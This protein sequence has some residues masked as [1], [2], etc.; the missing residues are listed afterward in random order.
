MVADLAK[1]RAELETRLRAVEAE[2]QPA[3]ALAPAQTA[4][5]VSL[6]RSRPVGSGGARRSTDLGS[7]SGT[8]AGA[9]PGSG[10]IGEDVEVPATE[11][12]VPKT[13]LSAPPPP[14]DPSQTTGPMANTLSRSATR[15]HRLTSVLD[16]NLLRL[17]CVAYSGT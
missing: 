11:T 10:A 4:A 13:S 2:L 14:V 6:R 15:L 3:P 9:G 5:R 17:R 12:I 7:G 1:T 8:G 16:K